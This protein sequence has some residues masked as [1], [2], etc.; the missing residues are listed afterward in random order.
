[1][2]LFGVLTAVPSSSS[3]GVSRGKG[4]AII[5]QE[6]GYPCKPYFGGV[7]FGEEESRS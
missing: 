6:S 2:F 5:L 1:M 3:F 4:G 7:A